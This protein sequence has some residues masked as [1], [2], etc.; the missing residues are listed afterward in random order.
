MHCLQCFSS[1]KVL[2]EHKEICLEINGKPAIK[3][4]KVGSKIGFKNFK[5]Q[6]QV[7]FAIYADFEAITEPIHGCQPSNQK[8][9]TGAQSCLLL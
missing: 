8:S 3:M 9:F 5:E 6:L 2:S 4:P 7:P 1:E